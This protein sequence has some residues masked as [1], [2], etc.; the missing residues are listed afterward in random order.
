MLRSCIVQ[1][2]SRVAEHLP[3]QQE[4]ILKSWAKNKCCIYVFEPT[5]LVRKWPSHGLI[6][7]VMGGGNVIGVWPGFV[8]DWVQRITAC[9]NTV[10]TTL[11][12]PSNRFYSWEWIMLEQMSARV[13]TTIAALHVPLSS[14]CLIFYSFWYWNSLISPSVGFA[15]YNASFPLVTSLSSRPCFCFPNTERSPFNTSLCDSCRCVMHHSALAPLFL[16]H[17]P[18]KFAYY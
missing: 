7:S 8:L 15:T 16:Y 9:R 12:V 3:H 14:P 1:R 6:S 10:T 11:D 5:E 13:K 18:T 2:I 17:E 4:V